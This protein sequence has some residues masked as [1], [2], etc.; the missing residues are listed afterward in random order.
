MILKTHFNIRPWPS[1][2]GNNDT[3]YI[4]FQLEETAFIV[5]VIQMSNQYP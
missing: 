5:D 2:R 1:K 4:D 3:G